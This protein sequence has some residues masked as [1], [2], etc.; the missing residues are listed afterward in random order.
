[1][2]RYNFQIL[3]SPT[4]YLQPSDHILNHQHIRISAIIYQSSACTHIH[5]RILF[6]KFGE[7]QIATLDIIISICIS[8]CIQNYQN[9]GTLHSFSQHKNISW[10]Q[11]QSA[12]YLFISCERLLYAEKHL[13]HQIFFFLIIWLNNL[14]C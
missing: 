12:W 7:C 14:Y 8:A 2:I 5:H 10:L 9:S 6:L 13:R 1:M 11:I 4:N 3:I